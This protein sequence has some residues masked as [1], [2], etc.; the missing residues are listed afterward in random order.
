M[1]EEEKNRIMMENE[2][3]W[4]DSGHDSVCCCSSHLRVALFPLL[5]SLLS[6][7]FIITEFH[8][9]LLK[10]PDSDHSLF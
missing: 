4:S 5:L 10:Y 6:I 9:R 8:Q 2:E 7:V 1:K 3:S